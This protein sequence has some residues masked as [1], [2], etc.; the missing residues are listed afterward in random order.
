MDF[1][2]YICGK[3]VAVDQEIAENYFD[4]FAK[5]VNNENLTPE[6]NFNVDK[7]SEF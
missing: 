4:K 3:P 5:I 7:T 6:Q 2:S 1:S